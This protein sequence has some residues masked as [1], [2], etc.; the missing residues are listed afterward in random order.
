MS[1]LSLPPQQWR[2]SAGSRNAGL[3]LFSSTDTLTAFS[4]HAGQLLYLQR[5]KRRTP[6]FNPF[7]A[8]VQ[9]EIKGK[10][11]Q[12]AK[13]L[14]TSGVGTG[15]VGEAALLSPRLFGC[16]SASSTQAAGSHPRPVICRDN[17]LRNKT[18]PVLFWSW[19][20]QSRPLRRPREDDKLPAEKEL[21]AALP[22][23][24]C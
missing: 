8:I 17:H 24:Q 2:A 20:K 13:K 7:S 3:D 9:N 6:L 12:A 1:F 11:K 16:I 4:H 5:L 22:K 23:P 14:T 21:R 18:L 19:C 10:G 15:A